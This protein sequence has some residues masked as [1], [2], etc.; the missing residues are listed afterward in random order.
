[1]VKPYKRKG[2]RVKGYNKTMDFKTTSGYKKW[3][4]YGHIHGVF[5]KV[6]GYTRVKIRGKVHKVQH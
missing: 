2:K 6:P 5:K 3:L 1:M 4:A